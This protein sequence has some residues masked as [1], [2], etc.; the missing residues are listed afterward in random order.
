MLQDQLKIEQDKRIEL[1]ERIKILMSEVSAHQEC[2]LTAELLKDLQC[3]I[4]KDYVP[5]NEVLKLK[6]EQERKISKVKMES[7]KK[8][9]DKFF[10]L[11]KLL[12]HQVCIIK[13]IKL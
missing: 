13:T 4:I 6:T 8:I 12:S 10:D 3:K 7:E 2:S 9:A 11:N 5:K 1:D